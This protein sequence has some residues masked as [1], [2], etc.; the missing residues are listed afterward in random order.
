MSRSVIRVLSEAVVKVKCSVA[1]SSPGVDGLTSSIC[2]LH[3]L[4]HTVYNS[5]MQVRN[6]PRSQS[7][8]LHGGKIQ[9]SCIDTIHGAESGVGGVL[10]PQPFLILFWISS[11]SFPFLLLL[12]FDFFG[13]YIAFCFR[14]AWVEVDRSPGP[15][16]TA[17]IYFAV[18]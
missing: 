16:S 3:F 13:H 4:Y 14:V 7:H 11:P 15:F 5:C 8:F 18:P 12:L 2:S 17:R 6:C 9:H 1:S 10:Y